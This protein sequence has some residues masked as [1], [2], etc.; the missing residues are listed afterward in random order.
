LN[1]A[2]A[3]LSLQDID[4][5]LAARQATF[6]TVQA[7]LETEGGLTTLRDESE[8]ARAR[9]LEAQ[10][11]HRRLESE[12]AALR[13]R[14]QVLEERLYGGGITNVRELTAVESAHS[15]A[16]RNLAQVEETAAPALATVTEAEARR[17]ELLERLAAR[18]SAWATAESKLR[19]ARDQLVG[20][21]DDLTREREEAAREIPETDLSL[22]SSLIV[23]K[24]GTAVVR[25]SRDV[26]QGCRVRLPLREMARLRSSDGLVMC[27][28]CGRIL[29][30]E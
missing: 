19:A 28:S 9:V 13:E 26:C 17:E 25:V 14:L 27:S 23:R 3:L 30:A 24:G 22:Y 4:Q 12:A 11:E 18:E 2:R 16:R 5:K 29:L 10:V 6:E 7:Q 21:I 1:V 15:M 20:D 8:K